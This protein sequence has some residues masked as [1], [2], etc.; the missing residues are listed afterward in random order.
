MPGLFSIPDEIKKLATLEYAPRQ[1]HMQ[2]VK[3]DVMSTVKRHALDT[4]SIET[5]S[6]FFFIVFKISPLRK[7]F[8]DS[9]L[10]NN[11]NSQPARVLKDQQDQYQC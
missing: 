10:F 4:G 7:W 2:L 3:Q 5:T 6:K 8:S 11:F 1:K 9:C